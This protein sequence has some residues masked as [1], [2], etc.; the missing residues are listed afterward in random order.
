MY[1]AVVA[2]L[3]PTAN[4]PA[5][6]LARARTETAAG[7]HD[8]AARLIPDD[9]PDPFAFAGTPEQVAEQARR[10]LDA[11]GRPAAFGTPPGLPDERGVTLIGRE[12]GP[13]LR[14]AR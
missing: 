14:T 2:E 8:E 5:D 1:L 3:D 13:M 7:R 11:G 4:V 6:L 10:L 9:L 12:I